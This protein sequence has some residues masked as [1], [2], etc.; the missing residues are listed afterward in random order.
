[1]TATGLI[2]DD[3]PTSRIQAQ[4]IRKRITMADSPRQG[5]VATI[6]KPA[7]HPGENLA[8]A[9]NTTVGQSS[10]PAS[11]SANRNATSPI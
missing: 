7:K 9:R 2:M 5:S 3:L 1:M 8:F 11:T 4:C 10:V 6:G